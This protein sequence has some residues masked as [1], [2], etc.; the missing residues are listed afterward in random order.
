MPRND[1]ADASMSTEQ[2]GKLSMAAL[3]SAV[4]TRG[5]SQG[6]MIHRDRDGLYDERL[7]TLDKI[8]TSVA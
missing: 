7:D 5:A 6:H 8:G 2:D 3:A 4:E 1:R